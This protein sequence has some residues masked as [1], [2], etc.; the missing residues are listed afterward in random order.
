MYRL[1]GNYNLKE[2]RA[3]LALLIVLLAAG[4]SEEVTATAIPNIQPS[5][6]V[7]NGTGDI[8]IGLVGPLT[9]AN[10]AYAAAMRRGVLLALDELKQNGWLNGRKISLI[11]RNDQSSPDMAKVVLADLVDKERVVAIIG[12]VSDEVG[13]AEVPL[14]NQWQVPW[15]VTVASSQRITQNDN[16]Y[17]FRLAASDVEQFEALQSFFQK[18]GYSRYALI[19]DSSKAGQEGRKTWQ[20]FLKSKNISPVFDEPFYTDDKNES[21]KE[22]ANRVKATAPEAIFFWGSAPTCGQL[23]ALLAEHDFIIPIAGSNNL[24]LLSFGKGL[25]VIAENIFLPQTFIENQNAR[26][27]DFINRYKR[28]F[29]TDTIDFPGGVA[30][31]YDA[32]RLLI[33]ALRKP[34]SAD[35]REKLRAA[36]EESSLNDGIIKSYF[37][38]WISGSTHEALNQQDVLI[39]SWRKGRLVY[40]E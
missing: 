22:Y 24:S 9:G 14:A 30:Q 25:P 18:R 36:L 7:G 8:K 34:G 19:T 20:T 38:P 21:Q 37:Q 2:F 1:K 23:R 26:Y 29:N 28:F 11:E 40:A 13:L 5:P 17:V 27:T 12:T 39:V 35:N 32:T 16:S 31:S 6:V 15:L 33:A 10:A 3:L 4:C